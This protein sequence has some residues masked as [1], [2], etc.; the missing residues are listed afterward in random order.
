M[1]R[2]YVRTTANSMD[3]QDDK[4][5]DCSM[6]DGKTG[7]I[8]FPN[9]ANERENFTIDCGYVVCDG[10]IGDYVWLDENG[11]G[12]QDEVN[13][14]IADV[15]VTLSED[16]SDREN[17]KTVKTDSDGYYEFTGLCP[18]EYFVEF[19][20]G[21]PNTNP[22]QPC[23]DNGDSKEND[24]D[25]GDPNLQCVTL[26]SNNIVDNTIDCGKVN[27]CQ[28]VVEKVAVPETIDCIDTGTDGA[29]DDDCI[30]PCVD[31]GTDTGTDGDPACIVKKVTYTYKITNNGIVTLSNVTV[32]DDKLGQILVE[33][34]ELAP[35]ASET[36]K[37]EDVC[38]CEET[39]NKV[40]V[41]GKLPNGE[42]CTA[43]DEATVTT[44]LDCIDTG[45]DGY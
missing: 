22:G 36:V 41:T 23:G 29:V 4:D 27:P 16:C 38:L 21:R 15:Y 10:V 13:T 31:S 37:V 12:C 11:N 26:D 32:F 28:L 6:D 2:N 5:S 24:S 1:W 33:F 7:C 20:N 3:C 43:M 18:G 8:T 42:L 35:G 34:T 19:G 9:P 17:P 44:E 25:C 14:G 40:T 39:T 30:C 45:T